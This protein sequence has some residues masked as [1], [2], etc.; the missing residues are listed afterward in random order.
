MNG[1][2]AEDKSNGFADIKVLPGNELIDALEACYDHDGLDETIVV[3]RSNKRTNIY[4]NGIR[5]QILWREDE[6]NTGDLLMVAKNNYFWTEQKLQADMLRNGERKE[7]VAQI[8]DFIANGET[9]VVRRV[10]RTRELYGFR[11]ADVT[12]AFPDYNDLELEVNLLLDTLHSDAPALP[13]ADNDRLF[14]LSSKITPIL[15]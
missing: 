9:A 10:R 3:C 14:I 1:G 2:V 4:N 15:R 7:V 13:K 6:L 5:A 8:P 12:L 11:F